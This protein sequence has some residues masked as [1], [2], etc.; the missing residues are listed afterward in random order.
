MEAEA[1]AE[2]DSARMCTAQRFA[3][4]DIEAEL[5]AESSTAGAPAGAAASAAASAAAPASAAKAGELELEMPYV[6]L[7]RPVFVSAGCS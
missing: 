1:E 2:V 4:E 5:A 3:M 6:E 7:Y